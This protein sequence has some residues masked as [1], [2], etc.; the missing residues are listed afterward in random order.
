MNRFGGICGE[1]EGHETAIV[2]GIGRAG[3]GPGKKVDVVFPGRPQNVWYQRRRAGTAQDCV[4]R[5]ET[6][7]GEIDLHIFP[8]LL[9]DEEY[10]VRFAP[11]WCFLLRDHWLDFDIRFGENPINQ[12]I[13]TR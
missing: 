5:S 11:G 4:R 10:F 7:H 13:K 6:F 12:S 3:G 1:H 9:L 8:F 2:R